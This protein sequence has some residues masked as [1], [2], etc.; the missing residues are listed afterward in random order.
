V[1]CISVSLAVEL[2][3][4]TPIQEEI[5]DCESELDIPSRLNP[6][7]TM[8]S[9]AIQR[10]VSDRSNAVGDSACERFLSMEP[11]FK[12]QSSPTSFKIS[13]LMPSL[14][15]DSTLK[16]GVRALSS[17]QDGDVKNT[18]IMAITM[19]DTFMVLLPFQMVDV[20]IDRIDHDVT[21]SDFAVH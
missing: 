18:I 14:H 11:I 8:T 2:G 16:A 15:A 1:Q 7:E 12:D 9:L 20:R 19:R 4:V 13:W 10:R 5:L 21:C 3:G 17:P 6:S